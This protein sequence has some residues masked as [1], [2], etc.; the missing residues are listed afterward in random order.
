MADD[1]EN[2]DQWLYGETGENF[3]LEPENPIEDDE[4]PP[5]PEEEPEPEK[6]TFNFRS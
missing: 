6:V 4:I 5:L 3:A 2:D 1:I